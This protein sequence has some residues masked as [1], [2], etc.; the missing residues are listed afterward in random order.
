MTTLTPFLRLPFHRTANQ[1]E[2][3]TVRKISRQCRHSQMHMRHSR[4]GPSQATR[5]THILAVPRLR[6]HA[7]DHRVLQMQP[8][9]IEQR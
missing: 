6:K 3:I 9:S 1:V 8:I 2:S 4:T 5:D 7:S